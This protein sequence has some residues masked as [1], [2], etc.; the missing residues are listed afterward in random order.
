MTLVREDITGSIV[1]LPDISHEETEVQSFR[2]NGSASIHIHNVYHPPDQKRVDWQFPT[3]GATIVV[4]DINGHHPDWSKGK[5]NPTGQSFRE[6]SVQ[7]SIEVINEPEQQ[8]RCKASP[9]VVATDTSLEAE[10]EILPSWMSDHHPLQLL[11]RDFT[12]ERISRRD[13][14]KSWTWR[15]HEADWDAYRTKLRFSTAKTSSITN[16]HKLAETINKEMIRAA[17]TAIP[18][19]STKKPRVF[20]TIDPELE[21]LIKNQDNTSRD[22]EAIQEGI[23]KVKQKIIECDMSGKNYKWA[24]R[25]VRQLEGLVPS[26][27]IAK[28]EH[29]GVEITDPLEI[30]KTLNNNFAT[31]FKKNEDLEAINLSTVQPDDESCSPY[32]LLEL[33][34]AL[35]H[36]EDKKAPGPD[37]VWNAMLKNSPDEFQREILRLINL[38]WSTNVVPKPW[39]RGEVIPILKPEKKKTEMTSYRPITLTSSLCKVMERMITDRMNYILR[40]RLNVRQSAF[41]KG[42]SALENLCQVT[43]KL[44]EARKNGKEVILLTFDLQKAFDAVQHQTLLHRMNKLR[45]PKRYIRWIQEYLKGRRITTKVN[46]VRCPFEQIDAG[47]SQGSVLGPQL[48]SIYINGLIKRLEHFD[49]T[50]FADD[51]GIV[52]SAE[53]IEEL[54]KLSNRA[55]RIVQDWAE[56]SDVELNMTPGKTEYIHVRARNQLRPSVVFPHTA[57][58]HIVLARKR[59]IPLWFEAPNENKMKHG[60]GSMVRYRFI[61]KPELRRRGIPGVTGKYRTEASTDWEYRSDLRRVLN[62][63]SIMDSLNGARDEEIIPLEMI[64][65]IKVHRTK[66]VRYL[67]VQF[68]EN[69]KFDHQV[70]KVQRSMS[71]GLGLLSKL[72][73]MGCRKRTLSCILV[74]VVLARS[75]FGV[76]CC[77]WFLP[78]TGKNSVE[79]IHRLLNRAARIVTGCLSTTSLKEL[80]H[81]ADLPPLKL[82][83]KYNISRAYEMFRLSP[84]LPVHKLVRRT[85]QDTPATQWGA[86]A[87]ET[88][89][90]LPGIDKYRNRGYEETRLKMDCFS[91]G[92]KLLLTASS[93]RTEQLAV[94]AALIK[95]LALLERDGSRVSERVHLLT[96]SLSVLMALE[97]GPANQTNAT[98]ATIWKVAS[99]I[100]S[101]GVQLTMY[102]VPAHRGVEMNEA[103][104]AAAK[105]GANGESTEQTTVRVQTPKVD[106]GTMMTYHRRLRKRLWI[107]Q[108]EKRREPYDE[109]LDRAQEVLLSRFRTGHCRVLRLKYSDHQN[110]SCIFCGCG[111]A[112]DLHILYDCK[113]WCVS[114]LRENHLG[115]DSTQT[116]LDHWYDPGNQRRLVNLVTTLDDIAALMG[117]PEYP[118]N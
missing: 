68:D 111:R 12:F 51:I 9:D 31:Q 60:K 100:E 11:V 58:S 47:V 113:H 89:K 66:V 96:D 71:R 18:G 23:R 17:K 114:Q 3:E 99:K 83:L 52:I 105:A 81:E 69:L 116:V 15:W 56:E 85:I 5:E 1:Q 22:Q 108:G 97:Q 33:Q 7:S 74:T 102:Y 38:S 95:L 2:L 39:K 35:K 36:L 75:L 94:L 16:V 70:E 45:I 24:F 41:R 87:W 115:S 92:Y 34:Q 49:P 43:D 86:K 73:R 48:F 20:N 61:S 90:G 91:Y 53:T 79:S 28:I 55:V 84:H 19:R 26:R 82:Q 104:D 67:G 77:A 37:G 109:E 13:Q 72:A 76:E 44:L 10:A 118:R 14:S 59:C 30:S 107:G 112:S 25:K 29:E 6:W 54:E 32:T 40:D 50:I 57:K 101:F 78:K 117:R 62:P 98:N 46:G 64:I 42:R 65:A 110:D 88:I 103:A 27:E 4:G 63:A 80:Y 106:Y 93:Y 8:T 21:K